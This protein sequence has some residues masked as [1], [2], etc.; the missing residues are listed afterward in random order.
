MPD[1]NAPWRHTSGSLLAPGASEGNAAGLAPEPFRNA[2]RVGPPSSFRTA[3]AA[4]ALTGL[5]L[6]VRDGTCSAA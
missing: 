4:V 1:G 3:R 2:A 5:K 6:A